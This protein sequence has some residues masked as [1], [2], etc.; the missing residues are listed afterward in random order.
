[1]ATI[2]PIS[3]PRLHS[4]LTFRFGSLS[5]DFQNLFLPPTGSS[6]SMAQAVHSSF[7]ASGVPLLG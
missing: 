4:S 2:S 6:S 7:P 5:S 1:M 3:S